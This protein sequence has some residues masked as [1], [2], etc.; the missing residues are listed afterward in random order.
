MCECTGSSN[1]D[2]L[3]WSVLFINALHLRHW[4]WYQMP[5]K[6][7]FLWLF[8]PFPSHGLLSFLPPVTRQWSTGDFI[9]L[10]KKTHQYIILLHPLSLAEINFKFSK[11]AACVPWVMLLTEGVISS[12]ISSRGWGVLLT[13]TKLQTLHVLN[14]KLLLLPLFFF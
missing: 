10:F 7:L 4:F 6:H 9:T 2:A 13:S 3:V 11:T 1:T 12:F 8:S 14:I 5:I